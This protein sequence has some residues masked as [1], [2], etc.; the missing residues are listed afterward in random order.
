MQKVLVNGSSI[1]LSTQAVAKTLTV[2]EDE[3][4]D[5]YS[6]IVSEGELGAMLTQ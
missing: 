4:S 5:K 1:L 3:Y 2:T 6:Y